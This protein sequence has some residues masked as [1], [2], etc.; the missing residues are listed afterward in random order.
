MQKMEVYKHLQSKRGCRVIYLVQQSPD[1]TSIS[2]QKGAVSC[3]IHSQLS[4]HL[5][6]G[7]R[8]PCDWHWPQTATQSHRKEHADVSALFITCTTAF[9]DINTDFPATGCKIL[10][11]PSQLY[12]LGESNNAQRV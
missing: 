4:D 7:Q 6:S 2:I 5:D 3:R 11:L 10:W 9:T 12:R 8:K 1:L